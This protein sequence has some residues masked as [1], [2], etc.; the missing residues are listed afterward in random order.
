MKFSKIVLGLI[1]VSLSSIKVYSEKENID[2]LAIYNT[3]DEFIVESKK[4][5]RL[6]GLDRYIPTED[7]RENAKTGVKLLF[8]L[9]IPTLQVDPINNNISLTGN[10]KLDIRINGRPASVNDVATLNPKQIQRVEYYDNPTIKYKD[11]DAV[12]D[13]IVKNRENGGSVMLNALAGLNHGWGDYML[14]A[15]QHFGRS[16]FGAY[17]YCNPM[18]NMNVWRDNYEKYT[19]PDNS[20]I[21]RNENGVPQKNHIIRGNGKLFYNYAVQKKMLL[22]IE[23]RMQHRAESNNIYGIISENNLLI[24]QID[25]NPLKNIIPSVDVY[26][27]YMLPNRQTIYTNAVFSFSRTN[28]RREYVENNINP[29]ESEIF[30]YDKNFIFETMWEKKWRTSTLT[31]GFREN[32]LW[33]KNDYY[34]ESYRSIHIRD[35]YFSLFAEWQQ[36]LDAFSFSL[37]AEGNLYSNDNQSYGISFSSFSFNPKITARY[38][39]NDKSSLKIV[40]EAKNQSPAINELYPEIQ[41]IDQWQWLKGNP[42]LKPFSLYQTRIEYDMNWGIFLGKFNVSYDFSDNPIMSIKNWEGNRLIKSYAN[43]KSW[44]EIKFQLD[45][46]LTIIPGWLTLS[47]AAGWHRYISK[48]DN[49]THTY[50]QPYISS[51]LTLSHNK[52]FALAKF[53]TN[54]NRLYGEEITGDWNLQI[55]GFGYT[56]KDATFMAGMTNPFIN[57]FKVTSKDLNRDASYER[58]YHTDCTENLVWIGV[59]INTSWGK[60]YKASSKKIDNEFDRESVKISGK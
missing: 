25:K 40:A 22:S 53:N 3:L 28:S 11:A 54:Y 52:W 32:S 14:S 10:G 38:K 41:Q 44:H 43:Q 1:I 48:G 29:I 57:N 59:T 20:E 27:Q 50:N 21:V 36:T 34:D 23:F 16:E 42:N 46:R 4:V 7:Q 37:G 12:V 49:Y 33:S 39:I 55:V 17:Y 2:S 15:K 45:Y 58:I 13:F 31:I 9:Q 18:W 5:V 60:R 24:E 19:F 26:F 8:D 51:Q 35:N 30:A 6:N 47:G 56:Y